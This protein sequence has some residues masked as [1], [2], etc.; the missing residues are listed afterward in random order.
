M[1][2]LLDTADLVKDEDLVGSGGGSGGGGGGGPRKPAKN[3]KQHAP[4]ELVSETA[5]PEPADS[6]GWLCNPAGCVIIT[7]R[8]PMHGTEELPAWEV[9]QKAALPC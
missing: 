5:V 6:A 2:A 3:P 9:L 8:G 1:D 7:C 4:R